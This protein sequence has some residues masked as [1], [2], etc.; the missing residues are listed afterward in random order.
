M[1]TSEARLRADR[2]PTDYDHPYTALSTAA[3][4]PEHRLPYVHSRVLNNR[5]DAP[6]AATPDREITVKHNSVEPETLGSQGPAG[7]S[8]GEAQFKRYRVA[9]PREVDQGVNTLSRKQFT[10]AD[11]RAHGFNETQVAAAV[12][13]IKPVIRAPIQEDQS[14]AAQ[15]ANSYVAPKDPAA[16]KAAKDTAALQASSPAR[17]RRNKRV[18][19]QVQSEADAKDAAAK[20]AASEI[21]AKN[22][23]APASTAQANPLAGTATAASLIEATAES[24]AA[25]AAPAAPAAAPGSAGPAPAVRAPPSDAPATPAAPAAP[26]GPTAASAPAPAPV[27]GPAPAPASKTVSFKMPFPAHAGDYAAQRTAAHERDLAAYPQQL[28]RRA[29]AQAEKDEARKIAARN[30]IRVRH[31]EAK[32]QRAAFRHRP[33]FRPRATH[34]FVP[35]E[36][37]AAEDPYA[38][39]AKNLRDALRDVDVAYPSLKLASKVAGDAIAVERAQES[40]HGNFK[41]YAHAVDRRMREAIDIAPLLMPG[42][43]LVV[44]ADALSE[45]RAFYG[46]GSRRPSRRVFGE[47]NAKRPAPASAPARRGDNVH[48]EADRALLREFHAHSLLQTGASQEQQQEQE[49]EE[50]SLV[51]PALERNVAFAERS[52]TSHVLSG[53][54]PRGVPMPRSLRSLPDDFVLSSEETEMASSFLEKDVAAANVAPESAAAAEAHHG[55]DVNMLSA[56]GDVPES[57]LAAPSQRNVNRMF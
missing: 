3:P 6:D 7:W 39:N 31:A 53:A 20:A 51:D 49:E 45:A 56:I 25:P 46:P 44:G 15:K 17:E 35:M 30:G 55:A 48:S 47:P 10:R 50:F 16:E 32:L 23:A 2:A 36:E 12:A 18:E 22:T 4:F 9:T 19:A 27:A 38:P 52:E 28:S 11:A 1:D 41:R 8:N 57:W 24:S 13:A 26:A 54:R 43:R 42:A 5:H 40:L 21:A 34:A 33:P 29:A 37:A 14:E